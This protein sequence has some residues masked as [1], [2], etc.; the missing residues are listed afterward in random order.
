MRLTGVITTVERACSPAPKTL[1]R[2][3]RDGVGGVG[4]G[5]AQLCKSGK[6]GAASSVVARARSSIDGQTPTRH[7]DS[8]TTR[9]AGSRRPLSR[10]RLAEY[11]A[12]D[13]VGNLLSK[14]DRKGN[15]IQYLYD[16]LY[17]LTQKTYPDTTT[18]VYP[19]DLANKVLR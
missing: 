8:P 13:L 12:Y 2:E 4:V 6:A 1:S 18:V 11:Y 9:A 7:A 10:R 15:T 17:R 5:G 19:Y 14:T 16:S 3:S